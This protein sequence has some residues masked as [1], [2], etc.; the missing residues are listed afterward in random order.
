MK[1]LNKELKEIQELT[2]R[3]SG[4]THKLSAEAFERG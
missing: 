4:E 1:S 3:N 2:Q